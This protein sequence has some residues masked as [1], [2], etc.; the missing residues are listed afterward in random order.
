[1]N[2][3]N[4]PKQRRG[5]ACISIKRRREIAAMGGSKTAKK[6][7]RRHMSTIG[8]NGRNKRTRQER[9]AKKLQI[10]T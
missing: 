7:G 1:M 5:F 3:T 6:Y 9:R 2:T 8:R 10:A 4:E